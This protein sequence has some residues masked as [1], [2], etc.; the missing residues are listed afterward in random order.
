MSEVCDKRV[1]RGLP[2][3]RGHYWTH[4]VSLSELLKTEILSEYVTLKKHCLRN[5]SFTISLASHAIIPHVKQLQMWTLSDH[6]R[7][8]FPTGAGFFCTGSLWDPIATYVKSS[9]SDPA[10][11]ESNASQTNH[12]CWMET[13]CNGWLNPNRITQKN[14]CFQWYFPRL[15]KK[16]T[17]LNLV[18]DGTISCKNLMREPVYI[19]MIISMWE[20]PNFK[21][22]RD[23]HQVITI[24]NG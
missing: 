3:V 9:C 2:V 20:S 15:L 8:S 11:I 5:N 7:H 4:W 19:M 24:F 13:I 12:S 16:Q 21:N 17:I 1:A 6:C 10:A 22:H 14:R 23:R 18:T